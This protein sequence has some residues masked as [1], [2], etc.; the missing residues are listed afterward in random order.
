MSRNTVGMRIAAL[1]LAICTLMSSFCA[2][3][4]ESEETDRFPDAQLVFSGFTLQYGQDGKIQGFVDVS[5]EYINAVGVYFELQYDPKIIIPSNHN[6]NAALRDTQ[7]L[8]D[9]EMF[10]QNTAVFPIGYDEEGQTKNYLG[11]NDSAINPEGSL[12]TEVIDNES[13]L[14]MALFPSPD[15][16]ASEYITTETS[17][18]S[19][20]RKV[21]NAAERRVSLGRISFQVV[22]PQALCSSDTDLSKV[23]Y[24]SENTDGPYIMY[25]DSEGILQFNEIADYEWNVENTLLEVVPA[26][27]SRAVTAY[28]LYTNG[29][30]A[31]IVDYLNGNM[32]AV[33]QKYSNGEQFIDYIVWDSES[34]GFTI[35]SE[36][37][38]V[39]D[40]NYDPRGGVTYTIS[41]NYGDKVITVNLTVTKVIITGFDYERRILTFPETDRP[42]TWE[43]LKMPDTIT[44][45]MSGTDDLYVPP[46]DNPTSAED[47]KPSDLGALATAEPRVTQTY[48]HEYDRTLF[49]PEPQWLTVPDGFSWTVDAI[50]SVAATNDPSDPVSGDTDITASVGRTDGVLTIKVDEWAGDSVANDTGFIIWLPDGTSISSDDDSDIVTV[51]ITDGKAAIT[52]DTCSGTTKT[53]DELKA[54]QSL[55]NLGSDGGFKLSSVLPDN[56][57]GEALTSA[58]VPF[59]F[60]AREN[61]YLGEDGN[62]YVLKDYSEGRQT[63][64]PVTAGQSL[65]DIATYIKF[66]DYS[67]IP[68]AYHGMTGEQPSEYDAAKVESWSIEEYSGAVA[69]PSTAGETVTL[70]GKLADYSYT[71]FGM[72]QNPDNVYLKIKVTVA[73]APA[74]STAPS[75]GPEETSDPAATPTPVPGEAVKITTV[76]GSGVAVELNEKTFEYDTQ[77]VGYAANLVQEQTYTIE[78]IGADD[79]VGLSLRIADVENDSNSNPSKYVLSDALSVA[80]LSVGET[81]EFAIRTMHGLP[82]GEYTA[83]VSVGSFKNADLGSFTISFEVTDKPVYRVSFAP[84]NP[85][86]DATIGYGYL[87]NSDGTVIRSNT[88]VADETVEIYLELLDNSYNFAGWT[89]NPTVTFDNIEAATTNFLMPAADV[90]IT[91]TFTPETA[92]QIRLSLLEDY[93]TSDNS[94]NTLRTDVAPYPATTFT[95]NVY[96]YRVIVE[97]GE[98][99]NYVKFAL[100]TGAPAG[101]AAAVTANDTAIA[102][103]ADSTG[104]YTTDSFNLDYGR[105]TVV[106]TTSYTDGD[107]NEY[108]QTYT[109]IILRKGGVDVTMRPGNSPFGIIDASF[110]DE[111]ERQTLKEYFRQHRS[112][113]LGAP[114]HIP[115]Y[116]AS[117]YAT[118]YSADAWTGADCDCDATALFIYNDAPFVDP[119]FTDLK[120]SDGNAVNPDSV[121]RT[122]EAVVMT[123]VGT[124]VLENIKSTNLS[125]ATITPGGGEKCVI[126]LTSYK[127]RPGIYKIEYAF[128]DS[129]GSTQTFS[130]PLAVLAKKG[131][132]NLNGT[133][134]ADDYDTLYERMNNKFYETIL[135]SGDDWAALYVYRVCD[136]TE[137]RNVNSIDAN[138]VKN[139]T[140]IVRSPYYEPLP[141]TLDGELTNFDPS[142]ATARPIATPPPEKA[143]LTLDYMG[144]NTPQNTA[145]TPNLDASKVDTVIWIGVG[146]KNHNVLTYFIERGLYSLDFAI[147]YDPAILEPYYSGTTTREK[148]IEALNDFNFNGDLAASEVLSPVYWSNAVLNESAFAYDKE[149][150]ASG[151]YKT[152][153][154]SIQ[155]KD[156]TNLRMAGIDSD[157]TLT[158]TT[159]YLLRVP[160]KLN[161]YPDGSYTGKAVDFRLTADTFVL[162]SGATGTEASAAYEGE[163]K[164]RTTEVNN[165]YNHFDLAAVDLFDTDGKYTVKGKLTAWNRKLPVFVEFYKTETAADGTVSTPEPSASPEYVFRWDETADAGG[166]AY[167]DITTDELGFC[168]WNFAL[169]VSNRFSYEMVVKKASHVTYGA[170][171]IDKD[172][173]A[174]D[175][176]TLGADINLIAGDING[177]GL[178]KLPD[179]AELMRFLNRQKPWDLDNAR[180]DRAD[181][182]GDGLVNMF[183][184]EYILKQNYEKL[185]GGTDTDPPEEGGG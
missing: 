63:M 80:A 30:T 81:T 131:D 62:N 136:V 146:V 181:L 40:E 44:P 185:Y 91:P 142:T 92:A 41:Q 70:V 8:E 129:D 93:N 42:E 165:L 24:M 107:G 49:S 98:A 117:T 110:N 5:V 109:L 111:T 67:T 51:A 168:E 167:G 28:S 151:R 32:N 180:F 154:I 6:T 60:D 85:G 153:F 7:P 100:K 59:R 161:A 82:V 103:T 65:A 73:E 11:F 119:G 160:F 173:V 128:T 77:T 48:T 108:T 69:L 75:P 148:L 39:T 137:D 87:R 84:A 10:D 149:F 58:A 38:P 17:V 14:T 96:N 124:D 34:D 47:W 88:Y 162:G 26:V 150:D 68:I 27:E 45:I 22:D 71:N 126:D 182:N 106:I 61:Y 169:P 21:V 156:G 101:T 132:V 74:P 176:L 113:D 90:V 3:T 23:L 97:S 157:T 114:A 179:R 112:Y 141:T 18:G 125:T 171:A 175:E 36:N 105:N 13:K 94:Q 139:K 57:N 12:F 174:N 31:D 183:D 25:I 172:A 55:I 155:S 78:N 1:W 37:N 64:F 152:E 79:I 158:E 170:T 147:D 140:D 46:T 143:V 89:S 2:V 163:G 86:E 29:T 72:V 9:Q 166:L 76:T 133:V 43:D 178:V 54:I 120:D 116:A 20:E 118:Y 184:L 130:R 50:R 33:I 56:S 159:I 115:K 177:D 122:I 19:V 104:T 95:E 121:T 66:P 164:T 127:I 53:E 123:S 102:F 35:T 144:E 138:A 99:Q 15:I 145:R 134:N 16:P 135:Q 52:V 4:A 83:L